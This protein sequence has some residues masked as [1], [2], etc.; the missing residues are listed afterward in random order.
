MAGTFLVSFVWTISS[1]LFGLGRYHGQEATSSWV[2]RNR[3][4]IYASSSQISAFVKWF[5]KTEVRK[6]RR[7]RNKYQIWK[8]LDRKKTWI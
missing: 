7:R 5:E 3:S 8:I 1:G 2:T 6:L 4:M